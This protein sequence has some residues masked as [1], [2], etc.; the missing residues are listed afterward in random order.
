[1]E[2]VKDLQ[3]ETRPDAGTGGGGGGGG[4]DKVWTITG[5]LLVRESEID[6]VP[7]D[8]PL[9]GI[10]V[11]VA[12][13]D[14]GRDGPWTDWGAVRT[15]ADGD[16]SLAETNNG[17]TRFFR[18]QARLNSADL[19]VEDGGRG[20]R[21]ARRARPELAHH[22]E[23][24]WPAGRPG[25]LARHQGGRLGSTVRARRCDLPSL[26]A[27]LVRTARRHRPPRGRGRLVRPH[28][29]RDQGH[30]PG[31][32]RTREVLER[33]ERAD[34]PAPRRARCLASR[35]GAV[36][37]HARVARPAHL[38][39]AGRGG[40]P[41]HR[42]RP[43]LRPV[44]GQR[45]D[46][47]AVGHPARGAAQPPRRRPRARIE[48]PGRGRGLRGGC[49]QRPRAARRSAPGL[50]E[51]PVRHRG[52]PTRTT[53]PTRKPPAPPTTPTRSA[54]STASTGVRCRPAATTCRCGTS[55]GPS[56]PTRPRAGTPTWTP[57][58]GRAACSGS[59][60]GPSTSTTSATTSAPCCGTG[61]DPLG[62]DEPFQ[63][64]PKA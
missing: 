31:A 29:F 34:L 49:A 13:S 56:G 14:I 50:V 55:C 21:V 38:R 18:V 4:G 28:H 8:R 26:G 64:L 58:T 1:M 11:R 23:V 47:R 41:E 3:V 37:V 60:T 59:S 24:E 48:H 53:G 36:P 19:E 6:G 40:L 25:G 30:L 33:D 20:H 22:L 16:F 57:A 44:R 12:A 63:R 2:T 17:R 10:E 9:K 7:H 45:G 27:G 42:V 43:R 51:P 52:R 39:R 32:R 62:A 5:R 35:R 15:D 46:A 54:S 61:I